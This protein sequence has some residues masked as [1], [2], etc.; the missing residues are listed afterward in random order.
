MNH[1]II[2]SSEAQLINQLVY[3]DEEKVNFLEKHFPAYG[4][5]AGI[6]KNKKEKM[7]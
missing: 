7:K 4:W 2:N 5:I 1:R 3:F 6:Y